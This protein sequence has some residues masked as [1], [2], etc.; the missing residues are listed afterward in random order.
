[1]RCATPEAGMQ[2]Y[3]IVAGKV[4]GTPL[5]R[6]AEWLRR[7][8]HAREARAHAELAPLFDEERQIDELMRRVIKPD[9][10][11]IDVGCHLG[12]YLQKIVT[13]APQA[14]HRAVEPVAHK[15]RWLR[16]KFPGVAVLEM[17]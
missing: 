16:Q 3:E 6:P 2:L 7:W 9:T 5:Q 14:R 4:I 8:K 11:C 12:A 15:A 13:L 17:A 10:N 1:M